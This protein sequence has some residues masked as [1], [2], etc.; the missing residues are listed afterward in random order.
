MDDMNNAMIY[1]LSTITPTKEYLDAFIAL[2]RRTYYQRIK[3]L[4][5]R[6]EEADSELK[7][8]QT[9]RQSLIQKNLTGVYSDEI[10]KEQNKL[11][12]EQI[13]SLQIAKSD[14]SLAKYNLESIV[15]FM[16]E[17]FNNLGKTYQMSNLSQIRVLLCS[18]FPSGMLWSYPGYSNTT[19]SPLYQSIRMFEDDSVTSGGG[20]GIRTHESSKGRRLSRSVE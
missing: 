18:I 16:Q 13:L 10:F 4:Q 1:L 14:E 12:E 7:K 6:K 11:I 17:K 5:K 2:L 15:N 20:G 3:Q 8:L 9:L 19:I